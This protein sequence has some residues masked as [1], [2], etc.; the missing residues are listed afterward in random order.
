MNSTIRN[1]LIA[2]LVIVVLASVGANAYF[3]GWLQ[4]E[5]YWEQQGV[6]IVAS[7]IV[8]QVKQMGQIQIGSLTLVPKPS[9]SAPTK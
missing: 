4:L 8:N 3:F 7:Q 6:N 5:A 2:L 1:M 9:A